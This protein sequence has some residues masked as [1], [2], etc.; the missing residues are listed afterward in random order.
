MDISVNLHS[1]WIV[2]KTKVVKRE[3]FG[4]PIFS[5]GV[6]TA[7]LKDKKGKVKKIEIKGFVEKGK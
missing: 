6:L 7:T 1:W 3:K 5:Q 2:A 4:K